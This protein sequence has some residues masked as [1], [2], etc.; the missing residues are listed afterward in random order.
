MTIKTQTEI[1][2]LCENCSDAQ[3]AQ[4]AF[5]DAVEALTLFAFDRRSTRESITLLAN[6]TRTFQ[7]L[8]RSN[9]L[10]KTARRT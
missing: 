5:R 4:T 1:D 8:H 6:W 7:K 2:E 3:L 9:L 10:S